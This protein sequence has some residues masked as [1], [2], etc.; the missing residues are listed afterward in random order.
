[1]VGVS[2]HWRILDHLPVTQATACAGGLDQLSFFSMGSS[3]RTQTSSSNVQPTDPGNC[4]KYQ[5]C[6]PAKP[7]YLNFGPSTSAVCFDMLSSS[8]EFCIH[9][10]FEKAVLMLCIVS[11]LFVKF[12]LCVLPVCLYVPY[13][14]KLMISTARCFVFV[15]TSPCYSLTI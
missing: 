6:L 8:H 13:A 11:L 10:W 3:V 5:T 12:A 15:T 4:S 1:M 2:N 14:I 7:S 9:I